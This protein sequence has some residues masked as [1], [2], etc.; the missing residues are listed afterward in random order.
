M[1]ILL[2]KRR[3]EDWKEGGKGEKRKK[4]RKKPCNPN[5]TDV[6]IYCDSTFIF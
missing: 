3:K 6:K 2:T 5:T 1:E 4:R